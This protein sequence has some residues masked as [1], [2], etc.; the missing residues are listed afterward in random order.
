M[1]ARARA[2]QIDATQAEEFAR[3]VVDALLTGT[4]PIF[5]RGGKNSFKLP[6]LKKL[7]PTAMFDAKLS[8]IFDLDRLGKAQPE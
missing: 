1:R 5:V 8:R 2:G 3:P 6:L 7:L 4:P